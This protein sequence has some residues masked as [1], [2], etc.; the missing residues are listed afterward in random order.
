MPKGVIWLPS[1]QAELFI[2]LHEEHQT[3]TE[4]MLFAAD[5]GT[6]TGEAE[7][8]RRHLP[9]D[10][11]TGGVL[12]SLFVDNKFHL[13][14]QRAGWV[15]T[16]GAARWLFFKAVC[17]PRCSVAHRG[18]ARDAKLRH[19]RRNVTE[20]HSR[21]RSRCLVFTGISAQRVQ[22]RQSFHWGVS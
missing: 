6:H 10:E 4:Q 19:Q 3:C 15:I 18:G 22:L 1:C 16:H 21:I 2:S 5:K 7:K 12:S 14:N 8:G 9:C 13:I 11:V 20:V 17:H